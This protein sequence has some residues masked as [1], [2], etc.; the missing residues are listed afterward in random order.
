MSNEEINV[1]INKRLEEEK[2]E[3]E[4]GKVKWFNAEKGFGFITK[5]D[6]T[7]VFLHYSEILMDGFKTLNENDE[8]EFSTV[9]TDHGLSAKGVKKI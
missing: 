8:V 1:L 5:P 2:S 3:M 4:K 6:G 9:Q 7:D